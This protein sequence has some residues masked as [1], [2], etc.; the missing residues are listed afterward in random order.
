MYEG[1]EQKEGKKT[2]THTTE[3]RRK[4]QRVY[5]KAHNAR[6]GATKQEETN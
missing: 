1:G 2:D 5:Q 4:C 3:Q 6:K